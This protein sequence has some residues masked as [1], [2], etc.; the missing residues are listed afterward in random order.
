LVKGPLL[1]KNKWKKQRSCCQ[2]VYN[3]ACVYVNYKLYTP[4][5]IKQFVI[6]VCYYS[7]FGFSVLLFCVAVSVGN[8]YTAVCV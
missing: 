3:Y 1:Y 2:L 8:R 4:I 7:E 6:I 5:C